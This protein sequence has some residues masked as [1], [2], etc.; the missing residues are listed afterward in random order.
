MISPPNELR[1]AISDRIEDVELSPARVPL[2]LLGEFQK[3]VSEFLKGSGKDVDLALVRVSIEKGSLAFRA[4]N[5]SSAQTLWA[6]L[7]SLNL[8]DALNRIDAKRAAVIERWQSAAKSNPARSY[9]VANTD[10][11]PFLS[12]NNTT[13]FR[14]AGDVW[15]N[16]EKYLHG[17]IVDWGGITKPN[18]HLKLATGKTL[19]IESSQHLIAEEQQNLVYKSALLHVTAEESLVT[20]DLRNLRLLA[21]ESHQPVY[22]EIEFNQ[23]VER[24]TRAW[25][26]VTNATE[27][28]ESLRGNH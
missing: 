28:L 11:T 8:P 23:M 4:E 25:S 18:V 15:V 14:L 7:I 6:D 16:V 9:I 17:K 2:A 12:V 26:N 3:D 21:I 19:T 27:W 22:D 1:F 5:L 20:G 24:G 13:D 10:K